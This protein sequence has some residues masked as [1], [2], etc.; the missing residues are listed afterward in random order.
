MNWEEEE[1]FAFRGTWSDFPEF[2]QQFLRRIIRDDLKIFEERGFPAPNVE[3][4]QKISKLEMLEGKPKPDEISP[5]FEKFWKEAEYGLKGL[6]FSTIQDRLLQKSIETLEPHEFWSDVLETKFNTESTLSNIQQQYQAWYTMRVSD[7]KT[8]DEFLPHFIAKWSILNQEMSR[9]TGEGAYSRY[10]SEEALC[11]QLLSILPKRLIPSK[12]APKKMFSMPWIVS[13][14]RSLATA[15]RQVKAERQVPPPPSLDYM[16]RGQRAVLEDGSEGWLLD[17]ILSRRSKRSKIEYLVKWVDCPAEEAT[18]EPK[19]NLLNVI[20]LVNE[21][22]KKFTRKIKP[23]RRQFIKEELDVT[24]MVHTSNGKKVIL[25]DGSERWIMDRIVASR[26][27]NGRLEY[28]VKW[29][30]CPENEATWE[31]PSHLRNVPQLVSDFVE[32]KRRR[33]TRS[34]RIPKRQKVKR[35]RV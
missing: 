27:R 32:R 19:S 15:G 22:D 30:G 4:E 16:L 5:E 17:K 20:D 29:E 28:L 25:R 21:F 23:K 3:T 12:R 18:W 6:M 11:L 7:F 33:P 10:I 9:M 2:R 8:V 14:I 26:R 24:G 1:E 34:C 13:R 35:E 31:P